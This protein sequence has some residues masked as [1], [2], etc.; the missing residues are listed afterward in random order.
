[1]A[2]TYPPTHKV[3]K[4][5]I[6]GVSAGVTILLVAIIALILWWKRRQAFILWWKRRQNRSGMSP[7]KTFDEHPSN[8]DEEKINVQSIP[9]PYIASERSSADPVADNPSFSS[10]MIVPSRTVFPPEIQSDHNGN[11]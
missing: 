1:M 11:L 7:I 10:F 9:R 2:E 5:L 8:T 4:G 3:S 6:G